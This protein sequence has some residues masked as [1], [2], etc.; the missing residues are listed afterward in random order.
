[1]S[2]LLSPTTSFNIRDTETSFA[3]LVAVFFDLSI[4]V[5]E[6]LRVPYQ[7]VKELA[8]LPAA[9]FRFGWNKSSISFSIY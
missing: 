1:M 2:D 9:T 8:T 4:E 6:M 3:Y 5:L 7:V